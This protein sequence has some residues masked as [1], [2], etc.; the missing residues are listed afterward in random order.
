M[1]K[2]AQVTEAEVRQE[3]K[4]KLISKNI[5]ILQREISEITFL[6]EKYMNCKL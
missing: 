3:K 6:F 4:K 1:S 5:F 2:I